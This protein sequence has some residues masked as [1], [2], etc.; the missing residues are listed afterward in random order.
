[1]KLAG[2]PA[3][4]VVDVLVALTV[5]VGCAALTP[6]PLREDVTVGVVVLLDVTVSVPV[7]APLPVGANTKSIMQLA[8]AASDVV[9]V[10]PFGA[11]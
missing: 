9:H 3:A 10:D 8:P 2:D 4:I 7:A 1:V 6:I 5:N 11:G